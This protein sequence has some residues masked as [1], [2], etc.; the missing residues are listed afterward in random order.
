MEFTVWDIGGPA[1]MATVNQCFFT[2]K[3]LYVVVWNLALGE[4][5][6]ASLQFWLLNIEVRGPPPS[7]LQSSGRRRGPSTSQGWGGAQKTGRE[8]QGALGCT[9][10]EAPGPQIAVKRSLL[11]LL[12]YMVDGALVLCCFLP[13]KSPTSWTQEENRALFLQ[14][15]VD[16]GQEVGC[17]LKESEVETPGKSRG[18]SHTPGVRQALEVYREEFRAPAEG[19]G[20]PGLTHPPPRGLFLSSAQTLL[21]AKAPNAVV[22]VVGTHLDLIETKFRVERIAT[23]RA[24]VLALCRSP[25]G[26]RATGFP[27]ITCKHLQ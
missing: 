15:K 5:A 1:S 2:D 7:S 13:C 26:S 25:S 3:A 11:S 27:D 8:T 19:C 24:Y 18:P 17:G 12:R 14:W 23:L 6:V 20:R 21:Q 9:V 16:V 4:E 10:T 22:L